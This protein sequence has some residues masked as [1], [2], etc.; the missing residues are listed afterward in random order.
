MK[1]IISILLFVTMLSSCFVLS[2][3]GK[4]D[5]SNYKNEE[6]YKEYISYVGKGLKY[7]PNFD[8]PNS[9]NESEEA[10][11]YYNNNVRQYGDFLIT[12][13]MDGICIND[14]VGYLFMSDSY[15]EDTS[16]EVEAIYPSKEHTEIF[17]P[18]TLGGA[19]CHCS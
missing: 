12:N 9:I 3:C 6:G 14:Y 18:E 1:K 2:A 5:Y 4:K 19:P 10:L 13:F 17:I 15:S 7:A 11:K 8:I 16:E